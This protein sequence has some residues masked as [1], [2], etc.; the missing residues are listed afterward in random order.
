MGYNPGLLRTEQGLKASGGNRRSDLMAYRPTG[1]PYL[2][3]ECKAPN[4]NITSKTMDQAAEYNFEIRSEY[5][6]ITNGFALFCWKTDFNTMN[7]TPLDH[8]PP[9]PTM[10]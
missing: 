10:S 1:S 4:I 7:L 6:L 8:I 5:L 3:A 2:L 9:P